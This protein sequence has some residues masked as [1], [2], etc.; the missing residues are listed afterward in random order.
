MF[1]TPWYYRAMIKSDDGYSIRWGQDWATYQEGGRQLTLTIDVGGSGASIFIGSVTR[2]DDDPTHMID[3]T[4]QSRI[5][6]NVRQ[7]LESKGFRVELY[8]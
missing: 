5:V 4:T 2:W 1:T 3:S 7:A 6:H 8:P